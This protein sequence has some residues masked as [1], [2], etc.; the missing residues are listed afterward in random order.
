VIG[1]NLGELVRDEIGG[2][3]I[4]G[5]TLPK[6]REEYTSTGASWEKDVENK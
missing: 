6:D 5:P 1:V 2:I 3:V 4:G